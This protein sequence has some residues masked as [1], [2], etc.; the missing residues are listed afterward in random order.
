M[1]KYLV[2]IYEQEAVRSE[3]PVARNPEYDKHWTF[4]ATHGD[5]ILA[6]DALEPTATATS[7]R[8]GATGGFTITD[9]PFVETKEAL[10]GFYLLDAADLDEA[11]ELAKQ[12]PAPGGGL[13][14]RPIMVFDRAAWTPPRGSR[15]ARRSGRRWPTRTGPSGDWCRRRRCGSRAI[16]TWPRNVCRTPM[17][18]R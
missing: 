9:G 4:I 5:K 6:S 2:L 15:P 17:R 7:L 3:Q 12:I 1:R 13:E 14:I 10:G 8:K 11:L 16:S 18:R